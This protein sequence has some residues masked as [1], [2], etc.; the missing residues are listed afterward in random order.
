[1]GADGAFCDDWAWVS[2]WFDW[3]THGCDGEQE[4][5][6]MSAARIVGIALLAAAAVLLLFGLQATNTFGEKIV[7]G[8]TGKY[9]QNTM[10]Y[11]IAGA[12][13]AAAGLGLTVFAPKKA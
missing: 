6:I 1:L 5:H 4:N 12:V 10:A 11:L 8:V 3:H 2:G 13:A 9:T 7:E